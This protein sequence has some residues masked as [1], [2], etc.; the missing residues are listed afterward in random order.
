M[1]A[2]P[3]EPRFLGARGTARPAPAGPQPNESGGRAGERA[4]PG[5]AD[6]DGSHDDYGNGNGNSN[7]NGNGNSD[8]NGNGNSD[9]NGNSNR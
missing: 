8:S 5:P 6:D 2:T 3:G 1:F 7:G 9:G 4:E